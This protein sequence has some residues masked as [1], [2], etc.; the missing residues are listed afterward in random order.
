MIW[1]N[2]LI[3]LNLMIWINNFKI[4]NKN[5]SKWNK[6]CNKIMYKM[7]SKKKVK[8]KYL[9]QMMMYKLIQIYRKNG[10]RNCHNMINKFQK[11]N[12]NNKS[13]RQ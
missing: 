12:I 1:I 13:K 6:L 4:N 5:F 11:Y 8:K 3:K 7:I 10:V 2:N 9:I